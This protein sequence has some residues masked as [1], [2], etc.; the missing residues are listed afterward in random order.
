MTAAPTPIAPKPIAAP[1]KALPKKVDLRSGCSPVEDQG[2]LGSCTANAL[3]GN[4]EF[5]ER[6]AG[7]TVT[8][9]S[10][11]FIYYN[12]R[13]MEGTVGEDAGAAT[14]ALQAQAEGLVEDH[15]R[16]MLQS[17]EELHQLAEVRS[18]VMGLEGH[19]K[20]AQ[21]QLL[22]LRSGYLGMVGDPA[23]PSPECDQP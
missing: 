1:P 9:L 8:N 12:E 6:K 22:A 23:G 4:L 13:D 7:H 2:Q 17:I 14:K 10:R 18:Q 21:S 5:L 19:I 11:L 20:R 3:V 16:H 15:K